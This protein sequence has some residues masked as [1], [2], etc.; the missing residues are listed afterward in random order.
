[1]GK[2]KPSGIGAVTSILTGV[3]VIAAFAVYEV[4]AGVAAGRVEN[5]ALT[6]GFSVI[7]SIVGG[8]MAAGI[9][10]VTAAPVLCSIAG[11]GLYKLFKKWATFKP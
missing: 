8:G 4:A 7:G 3:V 1:M 11:L 5:T 10:V 9:I 6:S 2:S